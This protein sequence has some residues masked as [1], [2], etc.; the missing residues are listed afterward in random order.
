[1]KENKIPPL[2][3]IETWLFLASA[4]TPELEVAKKI[5]TNHLER[6]FGNVDVAQVYFEHHSKQTRKYK[7]SA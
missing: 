5:A 1:M 3:L 7:A 6:V 4:R 2:P